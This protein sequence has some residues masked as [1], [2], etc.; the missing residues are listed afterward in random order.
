VNGTLVGRVLS[1]LLVLVLLATLVG[2]ALGQ[3]V[4]LAYVASGSMEPTLSTGDGFLAVPSGFTEVEEGDVVV[5]EARELH[6]GGLTTHRVVGETDEGYVTRGDAN[7]FTDQDGSEPPV[8]DDR[9]VA[10]APQVNGQVI[11]IPLLGTGVIALQTAVE[12]IGPLGGSAGSLLVWVGLLLI[13]VAVLS[14]RGSASRKTDRSRARSNVVGTETLVV[15]VV[16]LVVIPVTA[17]M[18]VPSG[19][20]TFGIASTTA[21]TDDPLAI[22]PGGTSTVEHTLHN[23][24]LVPAVAVLEPTSEE[25]SVESERESLSSGSSTSVSVTLAA[26]EEKGEYYRSFTEQRYLA[27]LPP[28]VLVWLHGIH[29]LVALSAVNFVVLAGFLA[30][31]AIVAGLRPQ[32]IRSASTPLSVRLRRSVVAWWERR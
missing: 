8:T 22:E 28:S 29:P 11:S 32:R 19:V 31:V 3:P 17:A 21:D 30:L 10:V 13:C 7:P 5:F 18:V 16:V 2:A 20:H 25:I 4:G 24:G 6:D 1:T 27:V 15:V 23:D 26:P 14:D 12:G 9:I